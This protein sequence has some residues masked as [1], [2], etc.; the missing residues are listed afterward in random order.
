MRMESAPFVGVAVTAAQ[1]LWELV[2]PAGYRL[3]LHEIVVGQI[4]DVGDAA[5]ELLTV[6]IKRGIGNTSGS[7]G[8]TVTP[9]KHRS[10][11][12]VSGITAE[13]NNTTPA[14]AGSGSLTTIRAEAMN[15]HKGY[16]YSPPADQRLMFE[17]GETVIV[18]LSAPADS[19]T[20]HG[21][22]V[23]GVELL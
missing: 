6:S 16:R 9:A 20:M 13:I 15:I 23:F 22:I 10:N 21:T 18:G 7:G 3:T 11:Q 1:D 12:A 5:M 17:A 19:L 8:S 2:V 4:T 14:V